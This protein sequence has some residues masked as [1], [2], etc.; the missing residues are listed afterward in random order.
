MSLGLLLRV[1]PRID[2]VEQVGAIVR[3]SQ[4]FQRRSSSEQKSDLKRPWWQYVA[5]LSA[6]LL[7]GGLAWAGYAIWFTVTHVRGS[8]ARVTG[9]VVQ[10]AAKT[11][12]RVERILVRTG[13]QVSEGQT[14]VLLDREDL[15]AQ[16]DRAKASLAAAESELARA[17]KELDLTIQETAAG[18]EESAAQLE[19]ARARLKQSQAELKMQAQEQPDEVRQALANLEAA[20][21]QFA[22]AEATL[23]RMEKLHAQGAVSEQSLDAA[24][25]DT[26]T[27]HASVE[28]AEAALALARARD[29]RSQIHEQAVATRR[30][31]ELQAAAELKSA[32][33]QMHKTSL[34]EQRV[35]AQQAA[36]AEANAAVEAAEAGLADAVLQSPIQ[37]VVIRGPGRSVKDGEV[38]ENGEPIVTVLATEDPYWIA[39][40]VSELYASRVRPGQTVLI[41]VDA[42]RRGLFG[43]RWLRGEIEKVGAAT[44]FTATEATPWIVQQVPIKIKF[45]PEGEPVRHGTTCRVWIDVRE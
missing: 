7:L 33:T 34:A 17:E 40:S 3:P 16:L 45:D 4:S 36:V 5:L 35:R 39:A 12:T 14:L 18:V 24:R 9:L 26:E 20:K 11:D 28:S 44:E 23:R 19:A 1:T 6:L 2:S 27:A 43:T 42:L 31:E 41:K 38:V 15:E 29:C 25:T 13:D 22:D 32:K 10:I 37:G 30:A 8:H 21:S